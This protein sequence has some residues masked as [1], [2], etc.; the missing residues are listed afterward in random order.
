MAPSGY[1][2]SR[3]L[4]ALDPT[5]S[6]FATLVDNRPYLPNLSVD[7]SDESSIRHAALVIV[8][9]N[10]GR[11][12]KERLNIKN[13]MFALLNNEGINWDEVA[14]ESCNVLQCT[15][16][17]GGITNA[18]YRVSGFQSLIEL[19]KI[20]QAFLKVHSSN[21]S[22]KDDT[23]ASIIHYDSILIRIFGAEGM[24][25][26]DI[27]TSTYA[28][29]C[30]ADIAHDYLGRFANGRV[31]GWLD[32]FTA[33]TCNDL[34]RDDTSAQ[35]A[36]EMARLHCLFEIPA[37]DELRD[38]HGDEVGLWDQLN[39]WMG[40]ALGYSEFKTVEDIERVKKL[41]LKKIEMETN[42]FI[43]LYTAKQSAGD[44]SSDVAFC[45]ND[46]LAANIM[47]DPAT[48]KI[49]L[50]DF[51]YGGTNYKAF[52]I[53]NH[54][55]EH[56]GGTTAEEGATPDYNKFPKEERQKMFCIEYVKKV[57]ELKSHDGDA[58]Q[59]AMDLLDQVK[60][61][62]LINHLYWGLWAVNQAAE[63]G[64]EEFDY[65]TYA[66][67]RFNQFYKQKAEWESEK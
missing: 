55:N 28:A 24:I 67:N 22:L 1:I 64:C 62:V 8:L 46:M 20:Q 4:G 48:N 27:E 53:A 38:H 31:E 18:L 3:Q 39:S 45:H 51:E 32:G 57:N 11:K 47:R 13:V 15:K 36:R 6:H 61:F 65:L 59:E 30:R 23:I 34:Q 41:E 37:G 25:N 33:L 12:D 49:Q 42:R 60:E 35:I 5:K 54:F 63:E 43:D 29:L 58:Q 9:L 21:H 26:R 50:I 17:T 10:A 7:A 66:T 19:E 56:A 40:Q 2:Q 44:G 16:V 14:Q 52:D